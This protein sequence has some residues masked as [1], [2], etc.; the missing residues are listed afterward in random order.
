MPV[1][2]NRPDCSA[3]HG[4]QPG[5]DQRNF[6]VPVGEVHGG[7]F[8]NAAWCVGRTGEFDLGAVQTRMTKGHQKMSHLFLDP[9]GR[10]NAAQSGWA[11]GSSQEIVSSNQRPSNPWLPA[12]T[13]R[14]P[15]ASSPINVKGLAIGMG[16]SDLPV[17]A[18]PQVSAMGSRAQVLL[19]EIA[20]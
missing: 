10:P 12:L 20:V 7:F 11:A 9:T 14:T 1:L 6:G 8:Q 19:C 17:N 4:C 5:L 2:S 15:Q 18:M 3:G 13:G 16:Q